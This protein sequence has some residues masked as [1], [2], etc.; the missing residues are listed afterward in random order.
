MFKFYSLV[1]CSSVF[2]EFGTY[3]TPFSPLLVAPCIFAFLEL[4]LGHTRLGFGIMF[5]ACT[6]PCSCL[7]LKED[8]ALREKC[9]FEKYAGG[10][11]V[12]HGFGGRNF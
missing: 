5:S 10:I 1:I 8:D 11:G 6:Y 2:V 3:L 4:L 7:S 12:L 9:W